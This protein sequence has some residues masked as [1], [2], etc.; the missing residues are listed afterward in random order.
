VP[1]PVTFASKTSADRWLTKKRSEI[2]AGL[3]IDERAGKAPL[4]AF[5]EPYRRTWGALS[6]S[7]KVA[8][9]TL[10]SAGRSI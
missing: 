8:Y 5:W 6:P 10:S 3:V 9:E 1:A 7:T 2:D 4:R